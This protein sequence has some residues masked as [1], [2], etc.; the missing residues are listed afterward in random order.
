MKKGQILVVGCSSS[1][2]IGQK[3]GS[4]SRPDVADG[5]FNAINEISKENGVDIMAY[6]CIVDKNIIEM[7]EEIQEIDENI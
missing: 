2:V 1:E 6:N 5:I 4:D 7:N 3:I